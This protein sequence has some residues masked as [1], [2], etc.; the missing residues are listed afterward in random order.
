M[1]NFPLS[2]WQRLHI[3]Y[4][5]P[6]YKFMWLI[7]IDTF[8]KYG[9]AKQVSS[10]NG[11]NT[12]RKLQEIFSMLSDPDQILSKYRTLFTSR[13]FGEFCSQHGIRH[14][15]CTISSCCERR[16]RTLCS[17]GRTCSRANSDK[18]NYS[19]FKT[20]ARQNSTRNAKFIVYFNVIVQY[21]TLRLNGH[22]HNYF[23][24]EQFERHW[25]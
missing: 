11:F 25:I 2:R 18:L 23:S 19:T 14:K 24:V 4:S 13:E 20:S 12:V 3:D 10:A 15:I 7:L 21:P 16:S 8:S 6:F 22:Y 9:K 1:Y 17:S 5:K